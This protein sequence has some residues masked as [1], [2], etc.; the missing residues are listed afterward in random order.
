VRDR[1]ESL[2]LFAALL[3]LLAFA[4]SFGLG[5]LR[6]R[7][8]QPPLAGPVPAHT[9]P[10]KVPAIARGRV[11]VLNGSGRAGLARQATAQLREAGFDVVYF[12]NAPARRDSSQVLDRVGQPAIARAAADELGIAAVRQAP[13]SALL[14]DATVMLGRDWRRAEPP[15]EAPGERNWWSRLKGWLGAG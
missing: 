12:G 11:E 7:T 15:A 13:D 4:A 6:P 10:L 14:L 1:L 8:P 9:V 2:A 3:L 5:L